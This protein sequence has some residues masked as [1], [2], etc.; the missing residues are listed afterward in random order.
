G[1]GWLR[2]Q[3]GVHHEHFFSE[4]LEDVLRTVRLPLERAASGPGIVLAALAGETHGLG[5]QMAAL[6]AAAAGLPPHLLG[7]HPPVAETTAALRARRPSVLGISVSVSTAG[8]RT[9]RQLEAL[10]AA[11]PG[12]VPLL[13]GGAGAR[14]SRPPGGCIIV[15]DLAGTHDWMRRL[16]ARA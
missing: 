9:R 16:A 12:S 15:E 10:R 2:G 6:A 7:S 11:V 1:D 5:L 14:R 4:R 8:P 3:L 13:V